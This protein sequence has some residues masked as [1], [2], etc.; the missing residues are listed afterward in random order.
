M[1]VPQQAFLPKLEG[2]HQLATVEITHDI[3]IDVG[4]VSN[5]GLLSGIQALCWF[6]FSKPHQTILHP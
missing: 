6:V 5:E 1:A 3:T 4:D 2:E